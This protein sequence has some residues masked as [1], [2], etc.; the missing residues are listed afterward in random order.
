MILHGLPRLRFRPHLQRLLG[1]PPKAGHDAGECDW[2]GA[3]A[4]VSR[5]CHAWL[6][7]PGIR[8]SPRTPPA[9]SMALAPIPKLSAHGAEIPALGL[10]TSS[11]GDCGDIVAT[12]LT[13]GYRLIDTAWKYGTERG[14]GEGMRASGVPRED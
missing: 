7:A 3:Y 5:N 1:A 11:L 14:V 9:G 2:T 10:G 12:A 4:L 13:L 8:S 6:S